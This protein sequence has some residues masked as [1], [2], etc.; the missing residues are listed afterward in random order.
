MKKSLLLV[1]VG[2]LAL[3]F[4]LPAIGAESGMGMSLGLNAG[5]FP[6]FYGLNSL[7]YG[8]EIGILFS[9]RIVLRAEI[10]YA[11]ATENYSEEDK[12]SYYSYSY[13]GKSTY[14]AIP[15]SAT[16]LYRAPVSSSLTANVGV[17][18]GYYPISIEQEMTMEHTSVY[19]LYSESESDKE[20]ENINGFAPHFSAGVELALSE[21][22]L[23]FGDIRHIIGKAEYEEKDGSYHF[24]N[25][26]HFGGTS[27]RIGIRFYS[28]KQK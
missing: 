5:G 20:T 19:W 8:G 10:S 22:F 23:V 27:V 21:N 15:I 6:F 9:Q 3:S 2:W 16:L 4:S 28:N 25:D 26:L 7:N 1:I 11:A 24:S 12:G 17:G 18:Y 14:K 13:T